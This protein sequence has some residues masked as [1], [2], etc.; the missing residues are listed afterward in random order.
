MIEE[1]AVHYFGEERRFAPFARKFN[2][3][4]P[5]TPAKGS[6]LTPPKDLFIVSIISYVLFLFINIVLFICY[7][8]PNKKRFRLMI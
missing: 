7:P 4:R 8:N 3:N 1:D 2:G 5:E 6:P